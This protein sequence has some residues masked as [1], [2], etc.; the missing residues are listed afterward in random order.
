MFCSWSS[1]YIP[2][3]HFAPLWKAREDAHGCFSLWLFTHLQ[4]RAIPP[5]LL[6]ALEAFLWA[7]VA[8]HGMWAS[9]PSAVPGSAANTQVSWFVSP[10]IWFYPSYVLARTVKQEPG[11]TFPAGR[12]T[13]K[14][15]NP[16]SC[17]TDT[18][19]TA[20]FRYSLIKLSALGQENCWG[21]LP[22]TPGLHLQVATIPSL[23]LTTKNESRYCKF[24]GDKIT[25]LRLT[26]CDPPL[27]DSH[28]AEGSC[29]PM[30]PVCEFLIDHASRFFFS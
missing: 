29:D 27:C 4:S 12:D 20:R 26:V 1:P 15:Q 13:I 28:H 9:G 7:L 10:Q 25:P 18:L 16:V 5:T 30:M 3:T 17:V 23:V 24:L 2:H 19:S 22:R 6:L 14:S 21:M 11:L 8:H